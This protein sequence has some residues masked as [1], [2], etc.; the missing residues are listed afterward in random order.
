[1]QIKRTAAVPRCNLAPIL[2]R[3]M[4]EPLGILVSAE[5]IHLY[6]CLLSC[7]DVVVFAGDRIEVD[8]AENLGKRSESRCQIIYFFRRRARD[9]VVSC[10]ARA[11]SRRST[12]L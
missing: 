5:E 6:C 9:S 1:M 3:F 7:D 4:T 10:R 2:W 8:R 11:H 12:R